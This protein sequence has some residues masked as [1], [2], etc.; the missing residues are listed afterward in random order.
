MALRGRGWFAIWLLFFLGVLVVV[1]T[2][3]TSSVVVATELRAAQEQRAVLEAQR[4]EL[5]QR[6]VEMRS[7]TYLMT[8]A[9][10]LGLRFPVDSEVVLL[11]MEDIERR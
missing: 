5:A 4:N 3:Q 11:E 8:R 6:L 10:S 1:V 9:E 7:R 2:R